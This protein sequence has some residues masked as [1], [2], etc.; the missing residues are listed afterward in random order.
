MVQID[1]QTDLDGLRAV[2][3]GLEPPLIPVK[4]V[5]TPRISSPVR[6]DL[7]TRGQEIIDFAASIGIELMDWQKYVM[8]EAHRI[9]PDGRYL[10]GLNA[11][12]VARQNGKST[13]MKVRA[14][15]G[16]FLWGEKLQLMTAHRLSTSLEHFRDIVEI[17][18]SNEKLS[19]QVKRIRWAHGSEEIETTLGTRLLVRAGAS[20]ARGL[21]APACVHI[22]ETRE[23]K[24]ETTWASMRYT[25]MSSENP[26]IWTYS[27]AGDQHSVVLNQLRDRGLAA[28]YGAEDDIG[29]YEWSSGYEKMDDSKKFWEGVAQANPSLGTTIHV[30]N[31]RAVMADPEDVVQTEVLCRWV[32]TISAVFQPILWEKCAIDPIELDPEKITWFGLDL[33]PDRKHGSLVAAQ[34]LDDDNFVVKLLHSWSNP[35]AIDDR[36]VANDIAPYVRSFYTE[37]VAYSK[38]TAASI[39]ARLIPAGIP[40]TEIE[41]ARYSQ[42][43]DEMLSAV[44]AQRLHH[45][46]QPELTKHVLSAARLPQGDGGWIIGRRASQ[47]AVCSAVAVA[48]VTTFATRQTSEVD[49]YME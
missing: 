19:S 30:D 5:Q 12:I 24:D 27:N 25:T 2:G 14:L 22:D 33:S 36:G 8:I 16:L 49:I 32:A 21:A 39:A 26:Q 7:P 9:K 23:M 38:R 41:G 18:E 11:T 20:A 31:L 44:T 17:I 45:F 35:N 43:C 29:W 48:L 47:S 42:A 13:L 28:S 40:V 46:N 1:T 37:T 34:K 3:G 10:H 6:D 4:G 15:A